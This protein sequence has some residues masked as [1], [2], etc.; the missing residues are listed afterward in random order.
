[1]KD[2]KTMEKIRRSHAFRKDLQVPVVSR[3]KEVMGS[4]PTEYSG[5][6]NREY[7]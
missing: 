5:A 4:S 2:G 7:S 3:K 1:M 6:F